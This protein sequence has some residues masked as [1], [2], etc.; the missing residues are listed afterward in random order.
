MASLVLRGQAE[1]SR[2]AQSIP[3][4]TTQGMWLIALRAEFLREPRPED[5][6]HRGAVASFVVPLR[7]LR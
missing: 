2:E 4:I 7:P 6:L 3:F 1:E 5:V